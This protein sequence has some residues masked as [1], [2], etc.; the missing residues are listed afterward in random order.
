[1]LLLLCNTVNATDII[2]DTTNINNSQNIWM[3]WNRLF[4]FLIPI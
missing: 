4:W 2:S 1:M 3:V